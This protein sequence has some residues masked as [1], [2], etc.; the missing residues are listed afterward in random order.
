MQP[1]IVNKVGCRDSNRQDSHNHTCRVSCPLPDLRL[2]TPC[3]S[4][5]HYCFNDLDIIA[6]EKT[7]SA[8]AADV[9][10]A[11]QEDDKNAVAIEGKSLCGSLTQDAQ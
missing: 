5:L 6:L 10:A 8:W 3:A 2:K 4:T 7:L 11:T 1:F 9:F